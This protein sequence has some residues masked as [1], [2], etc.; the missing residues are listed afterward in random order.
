MGILYIVATPIGNLKDI[1]LRAIE[2][3]KVTDV[4]YA[5]DTRVTQKLLTHYEIKTPIKRY[6]EHFPKSTATEVT[7][8]LQTGENIALVSD[9]GTPGISDPGSVLVSL[10]RENLP[11]AKIIA[12]PGAS[13][14]VAALSVS[15]F[16]ANKFTFLSY[17]PIKNKRKKFFAGLKDISTRPMVIYESPHRL[18]KTLGELKEIFGEEYRIFIS[19]ELTKIYETN[20]VGTIAEAASYFTGDEGRGEFVIIIP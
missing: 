4:I 13:A 11:N 17:P 2:I 7:R 6:N 5:E 16:P 19:K 9:A 1:T 12:I 14:L 18:H 8:M 3:L 20:F 10:V 15:G